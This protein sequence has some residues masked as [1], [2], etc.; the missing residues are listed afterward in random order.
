VRRLLSAFY[1]LFSLDQLLSMIQDIMWKGKKASAHGVSAQALSDFSPF[2]KAQTDSF[3]EGKTAEAVRFTERNP[4]I[5]VYFGAHVTDPH[6]VLPEGVLRDFSTR[7]RSPQLLVH[8]AVVAPFL[9]VPP[10]ML[11]L[12]PSFL[13]SCSSL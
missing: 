1:P 5:L 8:V 6:D 2:F 3:T 12:D 13:R 10:L 9:F 11:L 7:M 4:H